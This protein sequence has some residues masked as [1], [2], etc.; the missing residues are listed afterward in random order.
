AVIASERMRPSLPYGVQSGD[1]ARDRAIVWAR[2]DRPARMMVEWATTEA[3]DDVSVTRGPAA[4]EDTDFTAKVDL[5]GLPLGERIFYRVTMVDLADHGLASAPAAG[6]FWTPPAAQRDIRF[7][8]SA[9]TAGQGWGINPDWGG[10]RIYETMRAVEPAFFIHAGDTIYADGP[11]AAEVALPDGGVWK[12]L[13]T[14]AKSK[15]AETLAEFRG[16]YAYNLMDEHVRR[17][18]AAVPM[19]AQWD[20]HEV[21]NNWYWEKRLDQDERYKEKSVA[22]LAARSLRAF[23][24]YLPVRRHPLERDRIYGSFRYGPSLEV[25]RIDMRSY[26]GPN[27]EGRE[28]AVGPGTTILGAAQMRWLRQAL[29]ASDATWKVIAS[30]MP[31]GLVVW[32][33]F[34]AQRG[35]EAVAQGDGGPPLGRELEIAGL[36][37]F[38]RDN[39]IA[40]VVWLTADVHYT[41]AHYYDPNRARFQEFAPFWEFVSGPLNA[42]T[43]GPNPLDA[44]FGPQ[45][46]F[47]K[48]PPAGQFNL[49]PS[50]GLQFFGQVDIDGA[51]EVMTV[52][53]KDLAG[54]SL[55]TQ[56]LEP[57]RR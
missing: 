42:G 31:I 46:V 28:T 37:R 52:R 7:V 35:A 43:F 27:T 16:N 48:V 6:S 11:I 45:V 47:Q 39:A 54:A 24:E 41:T 13:T 30:D 55:F 22:L 36:L 14:E 57:Q 2:A 33:D 51:T 38:I 15:V 20:D 10:M 1:L 26:R 44:T 53:L 23:T 9:D 18:N 29:L 32:D 49:P 19:L 17:F 8:W 40:N 4:L 12:N 5:A 3:F 21:V 25:L 50:A 34:R 56:E